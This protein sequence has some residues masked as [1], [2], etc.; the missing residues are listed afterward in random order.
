MTPD[1]DRQGFSTRTA[2]L[3]DATANVITA[4]SQFLDALKN[5][6]GE[7]DPRVLSFIGSFESLT[8]NFEA[9]SQAMVEHLV[10]L[11]RKD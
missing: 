4:H 2:A 7:E 3:L 5:S 9:I 6:V 8:A 10:V 1:I 11:A